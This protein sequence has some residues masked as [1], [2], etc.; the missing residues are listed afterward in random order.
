MYS[1]VLS[2]LLCEYSYRRPGSE[3]ALLSEWRADPENLREKTM[4]MLLYLYLDPAP[5][6][7]RK[8][9]RIFTRA[10]ILR[11]FRILPPQHDARAERSDLLPFFISNVWSTHL[12]YATR[13]TPRWTTHGNSGGLAH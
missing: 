6:F 8:R 1:T 10:T 3:S 13:Y 9:C 4:T 7:K 5:L 11:S 2:C 12:Q